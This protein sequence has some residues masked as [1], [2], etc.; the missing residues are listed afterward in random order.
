MILYSH[1]RH[2]R[3]GKA[4]QFFILISPVHLIQ[5]PQLDNKEVTAEFGV[6]QYIVRKIRASQKTC[7]ICP[8]VFSTFSE[9]P[10]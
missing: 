4:Y 9:L 3:V 8:E 6:S 7:G 2:S 5:T 1:P 10:S